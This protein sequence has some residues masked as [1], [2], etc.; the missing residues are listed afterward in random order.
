MASLVLVVIV[1]LAC[2]QVQVKAWYFMDSE[3]G[4]VIS[5]TASDPDGVLYTSASLYYEDNMNCNVTITAPE[6]QKILLIFVSF[7]VDTG[8]TST[9]SDADA[10]SIWDGSL[11]SGSW[12]S[13]TDGLCGDLLNVPSYGYATST[14]E[15]VLY[16]TT[17]NS[18][19]SYG[20]IINFNL[21]T[22]TPCDAT[23][24]FACSNDR[25]IPS[26]LKNNLRDNCGDLS[27]EPEVLSFFGKFLAMGLGIVIGIIVAIVI[28]CIC[29]VVGC[30]CCCVKCGKK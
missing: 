24:E 26:E 22:S 9:C 15:T 14:N 23:T 4:E 20:F 11:D 25:C 19:N 7:E 27:D 2:I 8:S 13:P 16:W 29:C 30:I 1:T 5:L 28:V 3:C 21:Y 12:L 17:D 10:L 18:D 6:G